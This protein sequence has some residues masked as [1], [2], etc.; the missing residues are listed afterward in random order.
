[1]ETRDKA[2]SDAA[3]TN[4]AL[5]AELERVRAEIAEAR[6][7]A[8]QAPDTHDY[9]EAETR[10][11]FIDLLLHEAGWFLDDPRDREF[12][13]DGMPN[14]QGKGYVDYVQWGSD[15]R[16]LGL[17]EAKRT[18]RDAREGQ[19]QA[20]LFADCLEAGFGQRPVIFTSNGYEHWIWDDVRYPP[21]HA[22]GFYTRDELELLVQRRSTQRRLAEVDINSDIVER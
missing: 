5:N 11:Q 13:V 20:K 8:A 22:Q 14:T 1:M 18:K 12:E 9:S 17:V 7:A 21:R 6:K 3:A 15:G 19:H 2:L 10:D 16:P 4:A